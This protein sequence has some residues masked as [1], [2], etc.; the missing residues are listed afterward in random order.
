VVSI[1]DDTKQQWIY[2]R[3]HPYRWAILA[4]VQEL[5]KQQYK[6]SSSNILLSLK[7]MSEES[8]VE[9]P[10]SKKQKR[11]AKPLPDSLAH[12]REKDGPLCLRYREEVDPTKGSQTSHT[13]VKVAFG[14][15]LEESNIFLLE[16]LTI[17]Q[18]RQF[19]RNIGVSRIGSSNK[20]NC[21]RALYVYFNYA[22][23]L[24]DKGKYVDT[25]SNRN[26][27][28]NLRFVCAGQ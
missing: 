17:D 1:I 13:L 12:L 27:N 8:E 25:R 23:N 7:T 24:K 10:P 6:N 28:T 19:C 4:P 11:K 3:E 2:K 5:I 16:D 20:F 18:L 21:R 9:E 14:V 22:L 26:T 15:E